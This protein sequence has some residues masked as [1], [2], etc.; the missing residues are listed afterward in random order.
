VPV[1]LDTVTWNSRR[2]AQNKNI[3]YFYMFMKGDGEQLAQLG[4]F[5]EEGKI[6]PLIDKVFQ[7][8]DKVGEAL[9]HLE[10]GHC[11]GKVVLHVASEE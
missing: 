2:K 3:E 10:S 7:G 9:T 8:L 1:L 4:K 11:T 6:V 5:L